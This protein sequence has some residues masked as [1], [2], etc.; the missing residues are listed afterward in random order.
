MSEFNSSG[1][2]ML[3]F[4]S[5]IAINVVLPCV[6][7]HF[8]LNEQVPLLLLYVVTDVVPGLAQIRGVDLRSV[9]LSIVQR[10]PNKCVGENGA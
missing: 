10:G 5:K 9:P 7:S 6:D 1:V 8:D 4:S 2:K 3:Y